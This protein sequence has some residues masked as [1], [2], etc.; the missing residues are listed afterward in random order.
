MAAELIHCR[1]CGVEIGINENGN[2]SP[3]GDMFVGAAFC[4]GAS[5]KNHV[6]H[7]PFPDFSDPREVELWLAS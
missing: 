2:W 3:G 7:E 6:R 1:H 5:T 4:G